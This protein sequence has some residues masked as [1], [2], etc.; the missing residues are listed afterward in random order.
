MPSTLGRRSSED[1]RG[2]GQKEDAVREVNVEMEMNPKC[3]LKRGWSNKGPYLNDVYTE[4]GGV[5]G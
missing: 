1:G 2:I 3:R 5:G 4:R